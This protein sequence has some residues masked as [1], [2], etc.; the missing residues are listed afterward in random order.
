VSTERIIEIECDQCG[1]RKLVR[2]KSLAVAG[3]LRSGYVRFLCPKCSKKAG[4]HDNK[5]ATLVSVDN[6]LAEKERGN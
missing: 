4:I 2:V 1:A 5:L 3:G 6:E